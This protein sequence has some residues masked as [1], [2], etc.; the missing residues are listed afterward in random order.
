[1]LGV[2]NAVKKQTNV[3]NFL[4]KYVARLVGLLE[5]KVRIVNLGN[6]HQRL[7]ANLCFS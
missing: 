2:S 4:H 5:H 6:L 7:F 3:S 1:M